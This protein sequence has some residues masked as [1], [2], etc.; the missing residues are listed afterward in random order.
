MLICLIMKT[1]NTNFSV[2]PVADTVCLMFLVVLF[3]SDIYK[4]F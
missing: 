4:N 1:N 2:L 3:E